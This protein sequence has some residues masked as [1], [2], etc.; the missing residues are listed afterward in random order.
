MKNNEN[1]FS[2]RL[3]GF[4]LI[5]LVTGSDLNG[6]VKNYSEYSG[7]VVDAN[8][9]Q[10]LEAI[11]LMI[12]NTNIGTITNTEGE[13]L[14]KVPEV[15]INS[16]VTIS[17]MGYATKNRKLATLKEDGNRIMLLPKITNLAAVNLL[18]FKHP[19]DLVRAIFDRKGE[20]NPLE[21]ESMTAF[22]RE[23]IKRRNRNVSLTEAVVNL[24]KQPYNNERRDIVTLNKARKSTD[25]RRLD[26][27]A[28]KLQGG[29][30][31]TLYLDIMKYP[32]YIFTPSSIADY[33]YKF[34]AP[35]TVNGKPVY[36][37]SFV[38]DETILEPLYMGTLFVDAE[39]I[40]LIKAEYSLN[41]E[42]KY[43]AESL[44][45]KKKPR[46][47][48]VSPTI[49]EYRIDY[50][51]RDGKWHYGY[52]SAELTFRVSQKGKLFNSVYSL[53]SEMAVTDWQK[54]TSGFM[55]QPSDR[56][57]PSVVMTDEVSGFADPDFWGAYNVIEP[58]KSIETAIDKIRRK[59]KKDGS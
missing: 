46:N 9:Q 40:A 58:E 36:V 44:F 28:F 6:Q 47:I 7:I 49:A 51:E 30:F 1:T 10:P 27:V 53:T 5:A 45:V 15:D 19:E 29:P 8:T 11:S 3:I 32:E 37:V 38:Q 17:S 42:N 33:S 59:L 56:I 50:R 35:S 39:S 41:L 26:T 14:L 22:Y 21:A 52:G 54:N 25:Y 4:L 12:Q 18:A 57:R 43:D 2:I 31:T 48:R 13:F 24:Y 55:G 34:E 20:N 16:M 23:T